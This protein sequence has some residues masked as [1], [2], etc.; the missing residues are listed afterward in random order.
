MS[1]APNNNKSEIEIRP[2]FDRISK[3]EDLFM[4]SITL[5]WNTVGSRRQNTPAL[6]RVDW[7]PCPIRKGAF[8]SVTS[9]LRQTSESV[10]RFTTRVTPMDRIWIVRAMMKMTPSSAPVPLL[11]LPSP[12]VS[13]SDKSSFKRYGSRGRITGSSGSVFGQSS[14]FPFDRI[15]SNRETR[16]KILELG[17]G[18]G[19]YLCGYANGLPCK[20]AIR[21]RDNDDAYTPCRTP[22]TFIGVRLTFPCPLT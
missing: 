15:E 9:Q 12:F 20:R 5:D 1:K 10:S 7:Y 3:R 14:R 17:E 13:R 18:E 22:S 11:P 19:V 4:R 8:N 16:E 2:I 6:R 21:A